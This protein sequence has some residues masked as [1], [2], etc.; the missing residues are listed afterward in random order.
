MLIMSFGFAVASYPMFRTIT[1]APSILTLFIVQFSYSLLQVFY[2]GTIAPVL[3]ELFP[4]RVRFTGLSVS[5]GL[6]VT[7]FGG[8]APFVATLLVE[9]TG[10]PVSPTFYIMTLALVSGV[11]MLMTRDRTN[12]DLDDE[13]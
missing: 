7:F 8:T 4:T 1:D 9:Q 10:N 11:A 6:A 13:R 5:Y 12:I 2:T 3:A